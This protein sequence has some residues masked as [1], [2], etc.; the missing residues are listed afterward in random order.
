MANPV[1]A[2]SALFITFAHIMLMMF[3]GLRPQFL[4]PFWSLC[5]FTS[6][7]NHSV[8][9]EI[10]KWAD[11]IVIS[12]GVVVDIWLA[13]VFLDNKTKALSFMCLWIVVAGYFSAKMLI[14]Q[15][16]LKEHDMCGMSVQDLPH[17]AAHMFGTLNHFILV[18]RPG[19][20]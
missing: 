17:L 13:L 10:A 9:S 8:T 11:R 5:L 15:K 20:S 16:W 7:L 1:L 18:I 3:H 2:K 14:S 12:V 19:I 6:V 4:Y